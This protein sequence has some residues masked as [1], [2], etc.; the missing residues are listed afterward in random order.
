MCGF[1]TCEDLSVVLLLDLSGTHQL[2]QQILFQCFSVDSTRIALRVRPLIP[3]WGQKWEVLTLLLLLLL[4]FSQTCRTLAMPT[5]PVNVLETQNVKAALLV[6]YRS[7]F[8]SAV[9]RYAALAN[10]QTYQVDL[11]EISFELLREN[12]FHCSVL[13]ICLVLHGVPTL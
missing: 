12:L 10:S 5:V 8:G 3:Q 1:E 13:L 6:G 4:S 7:I 9:G 11:F 2:L